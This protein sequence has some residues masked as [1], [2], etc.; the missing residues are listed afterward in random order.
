MANPK[1]EFYRFKL[2][3]KKGKN[4]TF[5]DFSI[6]ELKADVS[7]S[8]E[9]AFM[10]NFE[11]FMKKIN[12]GHASNRKLKKTFTIIDDKKINPYSDLKPTF[13]KAK[14]IFSGVISDAW[15][16]D[17][18]VEQN[19]ARKINSQIQAFFH[20]NITGRQHQPERQH[21]GQRARF[22]EIDIGFVRN[23][24]QWEHDFLSGLLVFITPA[25]IDK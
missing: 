9:D 5:R 7:I 19:A 13:S 2:N 3:S 15:E 1:I 6:E 18:R 10:V 21:K 4:K 25:Y 22:N 8:N 16:R 20:H 11:Y 12:L 23:K 24:F 17:Q 14:N